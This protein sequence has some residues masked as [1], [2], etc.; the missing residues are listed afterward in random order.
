MSIVSLFIVTI[1]YN[2]IIYRLRY[3]TPLE[4][5]RIERIRKLY[6]RKEFLWKRIHKLNSRIFKKEKQKA[7][8]FKKIE[9]L[10][11]KIKQINID[12][13]YLDNYGEKS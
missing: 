9:K 7:R 1:L 12:L 5:L 11:K 10:K 4:S 2:N 3:I 6:S 8:A 13:L